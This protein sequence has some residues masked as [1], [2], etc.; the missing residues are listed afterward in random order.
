MWDCTK[1]HKRVEDAFDVCWNCGTTRDGLEDTEFASAREHAADPVS[2]PE[3]ESRRNPEDEPQRK[4]LMCLRC[5]HKLDF[6]GS[7]A[8][9][10]GA[11]WGIIGDLGELFVNR[12]RFDV[13]CCPGCGHVEFFVDV[14]DS[15]GRH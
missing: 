11:R 6:A 14:D 12:E 3:D 2:V 8:F 10:E 5:Q 9:H 13:Y 1:C 7:K 15:S 4:T